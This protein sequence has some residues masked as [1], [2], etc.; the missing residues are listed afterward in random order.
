MLV[1]RLAMGVW[2]VLVEQLDTS[3]AHAPQCLYSGCLHQPSQL[4]AVQLLTEVMHSSMC[5]GRLGL[6]VAAA[7][8]G[9]A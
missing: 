3:P 2:S 8:A 1:C 9:G 7:G 4:L 5:C 6:P